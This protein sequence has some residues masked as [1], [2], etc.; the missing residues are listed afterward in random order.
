MRPQP[1]NRMTSAS[2]TASGLS[3]FAGEW[4]P[5]AIRYFSTD[6]RVTNRGAAVELGIGVELA[7]FGHQRD[8]A[9]R[10][11][12]PSCRDRDRDRTLMQGPDASVLAAQVFRS[13]MGHFELSARRM[14]LE[15]YAQSAGHLVQL[16]IAEAQLL[17]QVRQEPTTRRAAKAS[18]DHGLGP[19]V[20]DHASAL[21]MPPRLTSPE[22]T[23][24]TVDL[25]VRFVTRGRRFT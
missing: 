22:P 19:A 3:T 2:G 1:V 7:A 20:H 25:V 12:Q 11:A 4:A 9:D 16:V 14:P 21:V 13:L 23:R 8:R 17:C 18:G 6:A 10:K 24:E 5:S 15:R